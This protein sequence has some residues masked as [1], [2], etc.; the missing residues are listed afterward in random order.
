VGLRLQEQLLPFPASIASKTQTASAI[1]ASTTCVRDKAQAD[2]VWEI[3]T[4]T[5]G[6]TVGLGF[7]VSRSYLMDLPALM[8]FS[9]RITWLAIELCLRMELVLIISRFLLEELWGFVRICLLKE[10]RIFVKLEL[11]IFLIRILI[12]LGIVIH[13]I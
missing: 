8:T 7:I 1:L 11:V 5:S 13:L 3:P 4:A 12:L 6:F 2:N 9:A 10:F